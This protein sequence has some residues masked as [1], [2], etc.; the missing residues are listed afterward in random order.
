MKT[1]NLFILLTLVAGLVMLGRPAPVVA[2]ASPCPCGN[3]IV[4]FEWKGTSYL[5][6]GGDA[7]GITITDIDNE[8]K[9]TSI[10]WESSQWLICAVVVKHGT[11]S[12]PQT[13]EPPVDN[14]T[15]SIPGIYAISHIDFCGD[16]L[17][18]TP[19]NAGECQPGE[20]MDGEGECVDCP[21]GYYCPGDDNKTACPSG[22]YSLDNATECEWCPEGQMPTPDNCSCTD[23]P[24]AITLAAFDAKPGNGQVTLLWETG[25]EEDNFGFNIYRTEAEDGEYE[26]INADMI[27]SEGSLYETASYEFVDDDVQNRKTYYY[28]LEDIDINGMS[29][30]HGP[31]KAVPRLIYGI[32]GR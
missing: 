8:S 18:A 12:T 13:F 32:L 14:G 31:V 30:V 17:D 10:D 25:S 29:T 2:G 7:K 27:P 26:M 4:K 15:S 21:C 11:L 1:I 28:K 19:A 22:M 23:I 9:P 16:E 3:H 24:S 6:E 20:Y 5:P